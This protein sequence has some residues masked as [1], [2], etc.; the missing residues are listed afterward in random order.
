LNA[1]AVAEILKAGALIDHL[2]IE[3]SIILS[4]MMG[5]AE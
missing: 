4:R 2:R 3:K 5:M 1:I